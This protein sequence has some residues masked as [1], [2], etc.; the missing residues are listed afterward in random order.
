MSDG[1][2]IGFTAQRSVSKPGMPAVC[3][4]VRMLNSTRSEGDAVATGAGRFVHTGPTGTNEL[5][6]ILNQIRH[7]PWADPTAHVGFNYTLRFPLAKGHG[8]PYI[9]NMRLENPGMLNLT[10]TSN[11]E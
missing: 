7:S 10:E 1:T 3:V 5:L 2:K 8:F 11:N 6:V 9:L 4:S